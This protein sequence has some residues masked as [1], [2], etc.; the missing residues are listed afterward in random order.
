MICLHPFG[1]NPRF[2][3]IYMVKITYIHWRNPPTERREAA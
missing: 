1:G 2:I 3:A